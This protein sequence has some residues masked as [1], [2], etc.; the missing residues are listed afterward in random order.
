MADFFAGKEFT[1]DWFSGRVPKWTEVLA[2]YQTQPIEVLEVGSYEGRSAVFLARYLPQATITC[3]DLFNGDFEQRFD[4]N[5]AE[6]APRIEKIKGSAIGVLDTF[7][8]PRRTFDVIYLDGGK[9][10]DH[11]LGMSLIAWR[12]LKPKGVMIWDD[13]NWGRDKPAHLRPHDGIDMFLRLHS[14]E[15]ALIEKG[16]QCMVRKIRGPRPAR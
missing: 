2:D 5:L 8:T 15:Y 13:Y 4:R 12:L 7:L 3:V 1:T 6:F 10:R 11:V 16:S 14:G 9:W